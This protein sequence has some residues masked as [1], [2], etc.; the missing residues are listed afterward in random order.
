MGG[1][2]FLEAKIDKTGRV[3]IPFQLRNQL[4][5]IPGSIVELNLENESITVSN[6]KKQCCI[7][8]STE[9]L[10]EVETKKNICEKCLQNLK[11]KM[12]E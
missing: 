11:L 12:E 7:C 5:L 6:T 3:L 10:K 9:L 8:N 4:N 2:N 1:E